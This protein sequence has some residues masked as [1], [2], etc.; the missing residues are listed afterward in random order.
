MKSDDEIKNTLNEKKSHEATD[1]CIN[2][3]LTYDTGLRRYRQGTDENPR[4][5]CV[6]K[7]EAKSDE[8]MSN[9]K[10]KNEKRGCGQ[11]SITNTDKYSGNLPEGIAWQ[12]PCNHCKKRIRLGG[13]TQHLADFETKLEAQQYINKILIQKEKDAMIVEIA[14]CNTW[15]KNDL[16]I[17]LKMFCLHHDLDFDKEV[18]Q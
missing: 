1:E 12:P 7:C 18:F 14:R 17:G 15:Q 16:I 3:R 8:Y 10:Q 9:S 13:V 2:N 6:F 5:Y 11:L 4:R